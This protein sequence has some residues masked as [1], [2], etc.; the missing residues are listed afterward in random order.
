MSN[1]T[2]SCWPL[3]AQGNPRIGACTNSCL[4]LHD[5]NAE[6]DAATKSPKPNVRAIFI[7]RRF[8]TRGMQTPSKLLAVPLLLWPKAIA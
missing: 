6:L 1:G 3:A 8:A 7:G 5:G 2:T 4:S